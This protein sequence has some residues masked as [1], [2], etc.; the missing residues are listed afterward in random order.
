MIRQD[1]HGIL[2]RFSAVLLDLN[3]TFMFGADLRAL[4]LAIRKTVFLE[5]W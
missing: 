2:S 3:G 5:F 1:R 4:S